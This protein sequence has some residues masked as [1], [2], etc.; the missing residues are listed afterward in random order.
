MFER[1]GLSVAMGNAPLD[2]QKLCDE[3]TG[4]NDESGVAEAILKVLKQSA[5]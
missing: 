5:Y 1:V 4:K 3:V 2:I